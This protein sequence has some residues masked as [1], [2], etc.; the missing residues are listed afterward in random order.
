[1]LRMRHLL[2][3]PVAASLLISP[4]EAQTPGGLIKRTPEAAEQMKRSERRVTLDVQVTDA[5]GKPVSGLGQQDF[6]LLDNGHP[7]ALTS[8][9]EVTNSNTAPAEVV[10]LLDTMNASFQDVVIERQ[11]IEAFLRQ[12]GGHLALPVSIVFLADTGVKLGKAS[13]DGNSL[14]EDFKKVPTPMRIIGSAQG[15]DGAQDRAQRSVRALQLLSTYEARKPGRKLLIWVGPGWPLLTRSTTGLSAQDRSRYFDSIV[16]VTTALR[17]ARTTLYSVAPLNLAQVSGQNPHLWETFVN[18]VEN[19]TQADSSNLALQVLAVHSGG[20]V[21]SQSGDL[22]GEITRCVV[23]GESYYEISFDAAAGEGAI[24]YRALQVKLGRTAATARTST[25]YYAGVSQSSPELP[26]V[27]SATPAAPALTAPHTIAAEARLVIVDVTALDTKGQPIKGL[28]TYFAL[29]EDGVPQTIVS[30]EEHSA[31]DHASAAKTADATTDGAILAT[32]KPAAGSVWN[33][34]LIDLYNTPNENR[35]RLQSQVEKF[36]SQLPEHE[37]VALATMLNHLKIETSFQD[38]AGAAYRY[39]HKN[40]LGPVD[41]FTPGSIVE[42]QEVPMPSADPTGGATAH[43]ANI[44]VERQDNRAQAT[45]DL[46][47][48]LAQWLAP[49][50]GRKNVY[51]LSGGFPLQGHPFGVAGYSLNKPDLGPDTKGANAVPMQQKTDKELESA[52]VAIYPV[53]ARGVAAPDV[54]GVTT[55]DTEFTANEAITL[56]KDLDLAAGRRQEMLE[57][58]KATGGAAQFNNNIASALSED[59]SRANT[60]YTIAYKP[61]D[62]EWKGA[63]HRIRISVDQ[64]GVQLAYRQG[65]Y[66]GDAEIP[67]KP[68]PEQFKSALQLHLPS[69]LGVQFSSKIAT[70]GEV[71]TVAYTVEPGTVDFQEDASGQFLTDIQFAILEYDAK[72]KVLDKSLVRLSGKMTAEQRAHLSAKTLSTQQT[73]PLKAGATTLVLGVRDQISGRFGNVEVPLNPH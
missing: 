27:A 28:S 24:Q 59:F 71:A 8:F 26:P 20:L 57:I 54:D 53:D 12:N 51:W 60:Y 11:G 25:A 29:H 30:V 22:A 41:S 16:D 38:G 7:T 55:A 66:A 44:D 42:R 52:R 39:L 18:G 61:P 62:K 47:S 33:V 37:P 67:S 13:Q 64:P 1:M 5:S 15:S 17:R 48:D 19:P 23:D 32:N 68:T 56:N 70:S 9:R 34:I 63:Y 2:L 14:A 35:G 31:G 58:A 40:G 3:L 65:Y 73:I 49:Y 21:L 10:L 69:E 6:T 4:V 50:P 72:G 36:L 46:F 45:L 43:Q